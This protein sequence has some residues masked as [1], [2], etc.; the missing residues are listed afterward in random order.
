MKKAA[1]LFS[2]LLL[3]GV[4]LRAADVTDE[5]VALV[6]K[7]I[8]ADRHAVLNEYMDFTKGEADKFW[9]LYQEYRVEMDKTGDA[10]VM[11]LRDYSQR[12]PNVSDENAEKMLKELGRLER[13]LWSTR[14]N[15][16]KKV[17]KVLPATKALRFAQIESRLD[18][19]LRLELAK[20]LDLVPIEGRLTAG[21]A[22]VAAY[23]EGAPGG[24]VTQ[25]IELTATVASVDPAN[26]RVTLMSPEG[27]KKTVKIGPDAINFDQI[28]VGDRIKIIAAEEIVVRLADEG[29]LTG[30]AG[31]VSLAPKGAKP[32]GVL[33]ETTQATAKV[34]ELNRQKRTATL[35]FAD[36]S[37]HTFGVRSDI[38]LSK[39]KVGDRVSIQYT[40]MVAIDVQKP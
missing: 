20:S 14:E 18:L 28:K 22:T 38:D 13:E 35:Q 1:L 32:G 4:S 2:L 5:T 36:G 31:L 10:L 29:T 39:H 30:S 33:A 11:L 25:T 21:G 15:C 19:G 9:P 6:R 16:I 3:Q 26:R 40:E 17:S 34:T 8:K 37:K 23:K 7:A 27:F 24:I 12:Y